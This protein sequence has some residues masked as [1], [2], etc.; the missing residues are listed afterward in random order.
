DEREPADERDTKAAN[1]SLRI[2]FH[3]QP[4]Q[5]VIDDN[6]CDKCEH[7]GADVV[8][9]FNVGRGFGVKVEPGIAPNGVPAPADQKIDNDENPNREMIDSSVHWTKN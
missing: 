7:I 6:R 5:R 1:G 2:K 4:G 8:R 9:S 3:D